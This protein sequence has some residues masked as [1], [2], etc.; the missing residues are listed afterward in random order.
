MPPGAQALPANV[1]LRI[2]ENRYGIT[3]G[4]GAA[5]GQLSVEG[6]RITFSGSNLCEGTGTYSWS[7]EGGAVTF[8]AVGTDPCGGRVDVLDG[9]TYTKAVP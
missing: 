9:I 6:D 2:R 1:E 5:T 8:T 3:R 7:L 4:A